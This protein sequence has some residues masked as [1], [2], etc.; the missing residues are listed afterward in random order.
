M[1]STG[2]HGQAQFWVEAYLSCLDLPP[3]DHARMRM[4]DS[5]VPGI[6]MHTHK[7]AVARYVYLDQSLRFNVVTLKV[8]LTQAACVN[9]WPKRGVDTCV[10]TWLRGGVDT[11]LTQ[12][13]HGR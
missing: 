7:N 5:R 6:Q 12:S 2:H 4:Q 13:S 3:P 9:T 1:H 8:V 10:N 11:V